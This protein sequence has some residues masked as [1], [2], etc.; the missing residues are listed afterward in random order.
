MQ[1]VRRPHLHES[2]LQ[3]FRNRPALAPELL[4]EAL[5]MELPEHTEIRID[6]ADFTDIQPAEYRADLVIQLV[7]DKPV[8]GI[9][10][11]VQLNRDDDKGYTWPVYVFN[12]RSR[13]RCPAWLL[14]IAPDEAVARWA[15]NAVEARV[16]DCC[17][18]VPWVLGHSGVPEIT[19]EDRAMKDPELAVLSSIAHGKSPDTTKSARIALLAQMASVGLDAERSKLYCDLVLNFLPEAARQALKEMPASK[20][21]YQ[22]EF[23]R[24]YFGQGKMEGKLEGQTEL[25]LRQLTARYGS[26][27]PDAEARLRGADITELNGIAER[28]LTAE[29]LQDALGATS[30]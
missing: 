14:V 20:Y 3:L 19:D 5:H 10:V 13:L 12:L 7:L 21:Q 23:A 30:V 28:L 29:T 4:R 11:E 17:R 24:R 8:L 15:R 2:L 1:G 22:S 27:A 25:I 18:F 6:S 16:G 9:V 26:V